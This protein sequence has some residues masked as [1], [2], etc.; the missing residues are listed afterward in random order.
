MVNKGVREFRIPAKELSMP[1]CAFA[2]RNAG[3]PLPINPTST[4]Y[5]HSLNFSFLILVIAKGLRTRKVI[6][7]LNAPT[8]ALEKVSNP[9]L[10]KIKELPQIRARP[11]RMLQAITM[12]REEVLLLSIFMLPFLPSTILRGGAGGE[13]AKV[14]KEIPLNYTDFELLTISD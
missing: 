8:S 2:K 10:I 5:F 9:R 4:R 7:I 13:V 3:K 6:E 14:E 11:A 1:V 12:L